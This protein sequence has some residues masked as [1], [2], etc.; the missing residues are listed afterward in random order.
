MM[1]WNGYLKPLQKIA[2]TFGIEGVFCSPS[3]AF[4]INSLQIAFIYDSMQLQTRM[5]DVSQIFDSKG[6][7]RKGKAIYIAFDIKYLK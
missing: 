4:V 6:I 5:L 3:I 1:S 2:M 7:Q